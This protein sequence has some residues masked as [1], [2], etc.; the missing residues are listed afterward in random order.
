MRQ[1]RISWRDNQPY[2]EDFDDV[3][4]S[5]DGGRAETEHVYLRNND[6]P[7]RW[8]G[9]KRFVI[10]ETGFGTGLNFLTTADAWL[11]TG[12]RDACLYYFSAEKYPLSRSDLE[13]AGLAWP[14]YSSLVSEL[15]RVW[16]A[17]VPGFHYLE[18]YERR[19]VLVLMLGDVLD[20]LRQMTSRV[21][22]WYLD[23]FAPARNPDMWSAEVFGEIARSSHAHTTFSTY[24]AAGDVRRALTAA[25]FS[26]E[27]IEG[28][29]SKREMLRGYLQQEIT[30]PDYF[31]WFALPN[32]VCNS[33]KAA[34]IGAGMAGI[35]TA[36]A[37]AI[38]G[39]QVDVY[40][41]HP[42]AAMAGSGNPAGVLLPRIAAAD[43]AESEFYAAAF[44]MALRQLSLLQQKYPELEWKQT[45][46]VQL[47]SSD[48]IR[49][50]HDSLDLAAEYVCHLTAAEA[51][52][53]AGIELGD[54]ILFYP[55]AGWLS[56]RRLCEILL[57]NAQHAIRTIFNVEVKSLEQKSGGWSLK[58][59][60]QQVTGHYDVVV[61]ANAQ[62]VAQFE[63][64]NWMAIQP[65]RG[66][67]SCLAESITSR[68]LEC[69]VCYDGY[70]LPASNGLHVIGASFEPGSASIVVT[71][72]EHEQNLRKLQQYVP[73]LLADK[74]NAS[75]DK[76]DGR[77]AVRAV[78]PDRMPLLGAVPDRE[79]F[80]QHY[81]DLQKGRQA[82]KYPVAQNLPGL[83]VN[84]GH[85]ARGLTSAFLAAELLAAMIANDVLPVSAR[86]LHAL[87]PARFFIRQSRKGQLHSG[88][89]QSGQDQ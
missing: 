76:Q 18:L 81:A 62:N 49:H 19:V 64:T 66:Q 33:K 1:A 16:P 35:T 83:F 80:R 3:Y 57:R 13:K 85:G 47:L 12:R 41:S 44:F 27:K 84:T 67:I 17:A 75:T 42:D 68:R 15:S 30:S 56:P 20:M 63:Q 9:N 25:G 78:T 39:W 65:A 2:S 36:R 48:R 60:N 72:A 43:S 10:G 23:G 53:V 40:D 69:P 77:A 22:A 74:S 29:S 52:E 79:Y 50:Q 82:T 37:L 87:H 59:N 86:V 31:P 11:K 88:Q 73:S 51:A 14:E 4:F 61:L 46:V 55:L 5:R 8:L 21:D 58:N 28:F 26:V 32:T 89:L 24:T 38:K 45:G 6:L 34:V 71:Q 54:D 7:Q 70:V